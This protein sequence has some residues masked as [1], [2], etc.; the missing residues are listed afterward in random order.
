MLVSYIF[1]Q[2][3]W[4]LTEYILLSEIY[5]LGTLHCTL[6]SATLLSDDVSF[7]QYDV[8]LSLSKNIEEEKIFFLNLIRK[9]LEVELS[10]IK[11]E[12]VSGITGL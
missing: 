11:V 9:A 12:L 4:V 2:I 3:S 10:F 6:L 1:P 7:V 5:S 8:I